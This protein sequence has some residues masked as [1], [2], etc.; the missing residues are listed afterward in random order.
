MP[1]SADDFYSVLD[2]IKE[3]HDRKQ[4]DYGR[5]ADPFANVRASEDWGV[6][7]WV[8]TLIRATDKMRRLQTAA[9]GSTLQNEGIED[10]LLD[11]A[12]YSLIALVLY[13][14]DQEIVRPIDGTV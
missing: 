14:E 5:P 13:R 10:S 7:A 3:L 8:G 9:Q 6:P 4:A 11:L 2:E 12:T 1:A